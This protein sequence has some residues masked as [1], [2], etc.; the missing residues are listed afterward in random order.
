MIV[1]PATPRRSRGFVLVDDGTVYVLRYKRVSGK[2]QKDKGL[3]IPT[4][5]AETTRYMLAHADDGWIEDTVYEDV[6]S[7]R[8]PERRDYQ[9]LLARARELRAQG[10]RVVVVVFKTDRFGRRLSERMRAWEELKELN[11]ELHAVYEGGK[12]DRLN[13]NIRALL[14]EEE[15][16]AL[17]QRVTSARVYVIER[18][19]MPVGRPAWG[20]RWREATADERARGAPKQVLEE[21]PDEATYVREAWRM[22]S[23]DG[24]SMSKVAQWIARLPSAARGDRTFDYSMTRQMFAAAVYVA[25]PTTVYERG[26]AVQ[27][28]DVLERPR[29]NWPALIDDE[30]WERV[31]LAAERGKRLPP[32][33]SQRYL[34]TGLLRCW[35]CGHRMD[36]RSYIQQSAKLR[37]KDWR[38]RT[39]RCIS[40]NRGAAGSAVKCLAEAPAGVLEELVMAK[41]TALISALSAP[42]LLSRIEAA[43]ERHAAKIEAT[44]ENVQTRIATATA[45]VNRARKLIAAATEAKLLGEITQDEYLIT[46]E[47]NFADL[48]AAEAELADLRARVPL[49]PQMPLA[50]LRGRLPDWDAAFRDTANVAAKRA[51]LGELIEMVLPVPSG[52]KWRRTWEIQIKPTERAAALADAVWPEERAVGD[53][54]LAN[55]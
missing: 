38:T 12:Q 1:A 14:S 35:R 32:Q 6:L 24:A 49:A 20:Y 54:G 26:E 19:W 4:Q 52:Q 23:E 51:V 25:R 3:S 46:R 31:Q 18:G 42:D 34:L 2:E 44:A 9:R 48:H 41:I 29:G 55:S 15:V 7:G 21:H 53:L 40:K 37:G 10:K 50:W 47:K 45:N 28:V 8:R 13:H 30:T 27:S 5:D 17:S 33:A 39:Y 43:Q 36:G 16:E 11:I 22:R